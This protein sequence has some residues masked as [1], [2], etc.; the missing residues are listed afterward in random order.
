MHCMTTATVRS[1]G[2]FLNLDLN[3]TWNLVSLAR[4]EE[5]VLTDERPVNGRHRIV[6]DRAGHRVLI[7][8]HYLRTE[9]DAR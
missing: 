6:L 1:G 2:Q 7:P 8:T 4:G 5:V 9:E 3:T